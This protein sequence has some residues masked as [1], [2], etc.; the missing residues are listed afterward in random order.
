MAYSTFGEKVCWITICA[1]VVV[2]DGLIWLGFISCA[3]TW[4]CACFAGNRVNAGWTELWNILKPN[5]INAAMPQCHDFAPR[6]ME[7]TAWRHSGIASP[8]EL[9]RPSWHILTIQRRSRPKALVAEFVPSPA[10]GVAVDD[11][12][13]E[14]RWWKMRKGGLRYFEIF[15]DILR[16][17]EMVS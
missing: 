1:E 4:A 11:L 10:E 17:F 6:R 8:A 16:Y 5:K 14:E 7:W 12:S 15:W 2:L 9:V 3:E 13:K